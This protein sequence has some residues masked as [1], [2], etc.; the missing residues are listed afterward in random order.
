MLVTYVPDLDQESE[1]IVYTPTEETI[2]KPFYIYECGHYS[3]GSRF[4]VEH[5]SRDGYLILLTVTGVGIVIC[6]GLTYR[7]A[8]GNAILVNCAKKVEYYTTGPNNWDMFWCYGA[9]TGMAEY[10]AYLNDRNESVLEFSDVGPAKKAMEDLLLH[11]RKLS[12]LSDFLISNDVSEALTAMARQ[13][14]EQLRQG[15]KP[16][17]VEVIDICT[18]YMEEHYMEKVSLEEISE[19]LEVTK[20]YLI[21]IYKEVNK[22]TPY[23]YLTLYRINKAKEMIRDTQESIESISSKCGFLNA[24]TFIRAFKKCVGRTPTSYKKL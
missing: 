20:Y 8:A 16:K 2:K 3:C 22:I 10:E 14:A 4:R 23:E 6:D 17:Q 12:E 9:G 21:R 19:M 13:K 11:A 18:R 5:T 15:V 24:N 1:H 7:V